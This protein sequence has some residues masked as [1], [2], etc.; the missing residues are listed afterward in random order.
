MDASYSMDS[1]EWK[2]Y[3][4]EAKDLVSK[5]LIKDPKLRMTASEAINHSWF[6]DWFDYGTLDPQVIVSLWNFKGVSPL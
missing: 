6:K 3:S 2:E 4:P 5:L 1:E